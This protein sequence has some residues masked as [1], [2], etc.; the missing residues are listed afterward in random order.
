MRKNKMDARRMKILGGL[1]LAISVVFLIVGQT[2]VSEADKELRAYYGDG[3]LGEAAYDMDRAGYYLPGEQ[4]RDSA[5]VGAFVGLVLLI[6]GIVAEK[7]KEVPDL[8]ENIRNK[9]GRE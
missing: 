3:F 7:K 1:V 4:M 5:V 8:L 6:S 9:T 2:Q